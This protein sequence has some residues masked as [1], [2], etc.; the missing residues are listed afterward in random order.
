MKLH[1]KLSCMSFSWTTTRCF[2]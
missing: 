1:K 2:V